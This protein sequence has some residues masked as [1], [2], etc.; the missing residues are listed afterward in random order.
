M[1]MILLIYTPTIQW[2]YDTV[3][4]NV[5]VNMPQFESEFELDPND[6]YVTPHMCC[7]QLLQR[8]T[9]YYSR[10]IHI[11]P[12]MVGPMHCYFLQIVSMLLHISFANFTICFRYSIGA[13]T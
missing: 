8:Y 12:A 9:L 7:Q 2:M 5:H 11:N 13:A 3:L 1:S 6:V 10:R 4:P